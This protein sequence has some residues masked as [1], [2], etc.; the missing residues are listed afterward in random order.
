MKDAQ[1]KLGR[2][3]FVSSMVQRGKGRRLAAMRHAQTN[4]CREEFALDMVPRRRYIPAAT[5]DAQ[6]TL[7]KEEFVSNMV[8]G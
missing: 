8:V 4:Q 7:R 5:K 3:E 6:I 1:I 2:K